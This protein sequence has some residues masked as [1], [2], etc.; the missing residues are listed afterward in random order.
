[1]RRFLLAT[2]LAAVLPMAAQEHPAPR[3]A[4]FIPQQVISQSVRAKKVFADLEVLN[5]S[6]SDKL[7]TKA[8]ELQRMEQQIKSPGLSDEGR[9]KLER[10]FQDL[11]LA[12]KRVQEDSQKEFAAA[13]QRTFGQFQQEVKPLLDAVAKEWK[14]HVVMQYQEGLFLSVDEAWLLAFSQEVA[15]RYDAK[16]ANGEPAAPAAKPASKPAPKPAK[17]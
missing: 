4:V 1:M 12:F 3:F 7:R 11:Q 14:L 10:E 16:Y 13:Q 2:S 17:K 5:K 6:L 8:E 15:K 9:A